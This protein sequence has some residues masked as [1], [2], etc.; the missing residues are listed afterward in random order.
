LSEFEGAGADS[1]SASDVAPQSGGS[2]AVEHVKD[3]ALREMAKSEDATDFINESRDRKLEAEGDPVLET[4]ERKRDRVDR[5]QRAHDRARAEGEGAPNNF[6][7]GLTQ[8]AEQETVQRRENEIVQQARVAARYEVRAKQFARNVPDYFDTIQTTF[9]IWEPTEHVAS[10]IAQSE[11]APHIAYEI[12]TV[13]PEAIDELNKLPPKELARVIGV[14]EGRIQAEQRH[15]NQAAP[16]QRRGTRAPPP[17]KLPSGGAAPPISS[18]A[19]L[20]RSDDAT[21]L[22]DKWRRQERARAR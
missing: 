21:A 1:S 17:I 12:S 5:Y 20:A 13:A 4:R 2:G 19:E 7:A 3:Q 9:S 22:I 15:A 6:D 18:D 8:F 10:A 16:P 14:L 11:F